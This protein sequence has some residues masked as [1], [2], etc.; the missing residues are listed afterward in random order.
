MSPALKFDPIE[1]LEIKITS[2]SQRKILSQT[3]L[4]QITDYFAV[5][6]LEELEED[7]VKKCNDLPQLLELGKEKIPGFEDKVKKYLNDFKAAFQKKL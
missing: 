3:L 2:P 4:S 6:I 7:E 5:R 1:F